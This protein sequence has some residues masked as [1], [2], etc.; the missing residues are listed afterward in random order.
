MRAEAKAV[1]LTRSGIQACP[2]THARAQAIGANDPPRRE[3]LEAGHAATPAQIDSGL[4]GLI[5]KRLVE[6][7]P[8]ESDSGAGG[9]YG[10][11]GDCV[12]QKAN[13]AERKAIGCR[14]RDAHRAR[15]FDRI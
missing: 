3:G 4:L 2:G 6:D 13:P 7:S 1:G 15:G 5:R 8:A 9:E 14:K 11:R 10:L 12:L